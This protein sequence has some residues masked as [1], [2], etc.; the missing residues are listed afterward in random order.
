[1]PEA[2]AYAYLWTEKC[3]LYC[4]VDEV[5]WKP[6]R[7]CNLCHEATKKPPAANTSGGN[8]QRCQTVLPGDEAM[9]IPVPI[10]RGSTA[11]LAV[12]GLEYWPVTKPGG[13]HYYINSPGACIDDACVWVRT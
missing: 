10:N 11:L 2:V 9:R 3:G 13:A 12:P 1:N 4:A 7:K 5:A 8:V 6:F